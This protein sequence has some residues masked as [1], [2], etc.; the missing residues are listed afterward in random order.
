MKHQPGLINGGK[1]APALKIDGEDA[2]TMRGQR[3]RDARARR[4]TRYAEPAA[5]VRYYS[6]ASKQYGVDVTKKEK[7]TSG[8]DSD[9]L[10]LPSLVL[11][12]K[13]FVSICVIVTCVPLSLLL[14]NLLIVLVSVSSHPTLPPGISLPTSVICRLRIKHQ[15]IY[16][17]HLYL[18]T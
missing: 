1:N 13:L 14:F 18:L 16:P 15:V 8:Y 3:N 12:L 11:Y 2:G 9:M 6:Y 4:V 7:W 5:R 10:C 17:H